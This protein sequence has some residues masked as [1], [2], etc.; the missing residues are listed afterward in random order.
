MVLLLNPNLS[1]IMNFIQVGL[2]R[3]DG[4]LSNDAAFLLSEYFPNFLY[5]NGLQNFALLFVPKMSLI[6]R[7]HLFD[8]V[9]LVSGLS[10][11]LD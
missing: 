6:F 8:F 3:P 1:H 7:H 9:G 11:L 2:L 5:L 4:H 10:N